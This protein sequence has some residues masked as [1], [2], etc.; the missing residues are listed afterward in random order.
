MNRPIAACTLM[1]SGLVYSATD[2]GVVAVMGASEENDRD[3]LEETKRIMERLVRTPPKPH[4]PKSDDN[5]TGK[6]G[7]MPKNLKS[8]R[9]AEKSG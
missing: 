1:G 8:K 5:R 6:K 7:E 9:P 2:S 3:D 4:K